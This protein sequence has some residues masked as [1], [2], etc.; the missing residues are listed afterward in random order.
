MSQ[1]TTNKE[2]MTALNRARCVILILEQTVGEMQF[3]EPFCAAAMAETLSI[4][5]E[6]INEVYNYNDRL[7][8][9]SRRGSTKKP[10][11]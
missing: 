5:C 2:A 4:A 1:V 11:A 9:A 8:I 3:E 6:L 10:S 7:E